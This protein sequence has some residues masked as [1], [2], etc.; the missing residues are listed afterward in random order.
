MYEFTATSQFCI[1]RVAEFSATEICSFFIGKNNG[2][3]THTNTAVRV[4]RLA[5][6]LNRNKVKDG[7]R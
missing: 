3:P 5:G 6:L 2:S 1:L 4:V 7:I